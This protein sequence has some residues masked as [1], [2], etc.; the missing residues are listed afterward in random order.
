MPRKRATKAEM[1]HR[2]DTIIEICNELGPITIRG[3]YYQLI[4]RG[5]FD[6]SDSADAVSNACVKLRIN[7]ELPW[8]L[9]ADNTRQRQVYQTFESVEHALEVTALTYRK[10]A[11]KALDI[12]IEFW[13]EKDALSNLIFPITSKW[14]IPLIATRGQPSL[15]LVHDAYKSLLPNTYIYVLTDFDQSGFEIYNTINHYFTHFINEDGNLSIDDLH[16]QRIMLDASQITD[17][18]LITRP[19][20]AK[21]KKHNFT[22]CCELDAIPPQIMRSEVNR[23]IQKHVS[24]PELEQIRDIEAME[25]KGIREAFSYIR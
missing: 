20:K 6:K 5:L 7:G 4:A 16:I 25:R 22:H 19:P 21:D 15:T 24:I 10:N 9:I 3:I 14:D 13:C 2:Y 11:M 18:E 12:N 8:D 1:R 17:W 23:Y